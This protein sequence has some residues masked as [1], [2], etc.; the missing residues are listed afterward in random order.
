M[1]N[2]ITQELLEERITETRLNALCRVTGDAKIALL[3]N[4]IGRAESLIDGYASIRYEIP[5][6]SNELTEEWALTIAE[7]ELY[8]RSSANDVPAK[9]KESYED[10]L[11]LLADLASGSLAI[12]SAVEPEPA[13]DEGS[14]IAVRSNSPLMNEDNLKGF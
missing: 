3:N 11:K 5:L 4:V 2:Y 12:P 8:K 10:T 14:S 1:S 6:P 7:Y 13:N 9:I